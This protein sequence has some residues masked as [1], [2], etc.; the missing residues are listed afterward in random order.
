MSER[1]TYRFGPLE[2]RGILGGIRAGQAASLATGVLLAVT[3]LDAA[4]TAGGVLVA[5][6]ALVVAAC[7]SRSRRSV[8]D[9]CMSGRRS[10]R[11]PLA[12]GPR[13][14][15]HGRRCPITG[16]RARVGRMRRAPVDE[17]A[18]EA[19]REL[20]D[21]RIL[22]GDYRGRA[23][24][25]LSDRRGRW[26]TAVLACRV[27]AF[28]LLDGEAQERRLARWGLVL[29]GAG[30]VGRSGEFSGSS[31][32]RRRRATSSYAGCTPSATRRSPHAERR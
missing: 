4:P 5:A 27:V 9:R 10:S 6:L 19:P 8:G 25:I 26:L 29:S 17:P 32:Q 24:G 15:W 16:V 23:I 13:R 2:R 31:G 7:A 1:L 30:G 14:S 22:T 11:H 21:V 18:P 12:R 20:R 28:S 3:A